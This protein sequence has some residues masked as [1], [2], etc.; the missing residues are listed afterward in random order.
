MC[1]PNEFD[2]ITLQ[3]ELKRRNEVMG[4]KSLMEGKLRQRVQ[5]F[6]M[7]IETSIESKRK[8]LSTELI[9]ISKSRKS[10]MGKLTPFDR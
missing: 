2:P 10:N 7:N 3:L 5:N 4:M 9:G 8:T 1:T 6:K